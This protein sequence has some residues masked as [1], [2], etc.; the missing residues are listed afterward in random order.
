MAMP[1]PVQC[2][3]PE[4]EARAR[5][6]EAH[7][8]KMVRCKRCGKP[9]IARPTRDGGSVDTGKNTPSNQPADPFPSLPAVFGRYRVLQLLGGGGM[10][11][12]YLAEDTQLARQVALKIPLF[13]GKSASQRAERFLREAQAAAALHHPNICTVFDVGQIDGRPYLTMAYIE[14][15]SL[16]EFIDPDELMPVT[17]ALDLAGKIALALAESHAKGIV[18]RDL[19]PA[20]I[21]ITQRGEPVVMDFGLAKR[22][23]ESDAQEARLTREGAILGTPSYMAP[24]QVNGDL[25][26]IGPATDIYALGVILFEMLTGQTPFQGSLTA[27]LGQILASPVPKPR[28]LR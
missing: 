19:K 23:D 27:I 18:H 2:P 25:A 16:E 22:N 8:G 24:E 5:V 28:D 17:R 11:A 7:T 13:E 20:N 21:M 14:G 12:V 10:G 3:N 26:K 4:C 15:R 9:F 6:A 1:I